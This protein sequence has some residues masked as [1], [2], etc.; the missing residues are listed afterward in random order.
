M[1]VK[2]R[3]TTRKAAESGTVTDTSP[4]VAKARRDL[5]ALFDV[6][7]PKQEAY[8]LSAPFKSPVKMP[9]ESY[10]V[11]SL[12]LTDYLF[13]GVYFGKRATAIFNL[14]PLDAQ[15]FRHAE[16]SPSNIMQAFPAMAAVFQEILVD[17]DEELKGY[18]LVAG[19]DALETLGKMT[20]S[21][22]ESRVRIYADE[23]EVKKKA[24]KAAEEN[25]YESNP[26]WG[27]F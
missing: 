5:I 26:N 18:L 12:P 27:L 14:T 2:R 17:A 10:K 13:S 1:R 8:T 3:A 15:D 25:F 9:D 16:L 19:S 4:H 20:Q 23:E 24:A 22:L 6:K 21:Y 7:G 11:E